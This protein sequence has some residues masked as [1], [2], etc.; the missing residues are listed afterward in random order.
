MLSDLHNIIAKLEERLKP[1][2]SDK[3]PIELLSCAITDKPLLQ[4]GRQLDFKYTSQDEKMQRVKE[5]VLTDTRAS[6][7]EFV[8][9]KFTKQHNL[10]IIKLAYPCKLK[11]ANNNL[12]LI[13]IHC[14]Q[15]HFWLG[16]HYDKLLCFVITFGKFDLILGMP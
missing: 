15:L 5:H 7:V 16:D 2:Q 6:A 11:L 3:S 1:C 9:A 4:D 14:T 10:L 12:A 13:V 8:S